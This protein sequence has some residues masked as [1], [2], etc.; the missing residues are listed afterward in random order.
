[1]E[2]ITLSSA[3]VSITTGANSSYIGG[4]VGTTDWIISNCYAKG[5]ISGDTIIG[6]FVGNNSYE[7]AFCYSTGSVVG[8]TTD[9]GFCGSNT[10]TIDDCFW[11]TD[12]S[13]MTTSDG[14]T[15]ETTVNM[16]NSTTYTA[17]GWDFVLEDTNGMDDYWCLFPDTYPRFSFTAI[18]GD[19][20]FDGTVDS[21]DP[22][23]LADH[24]LNTN[25]GPTRCDYNDDGIVDTLDFTY[26]K[27]Y[28]QR[29]LLR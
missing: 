15:G 6:G 28:W 4:F 27:K 3:D 26:I 24:W 2:G 16:Q 23:Y 19:A 9:G 14:G 7:I 11:D 18:P 22:A 20:N 12:T 10:H 5:D 25:T 13:G 8:N 21:M 1:M 29:S 17:A